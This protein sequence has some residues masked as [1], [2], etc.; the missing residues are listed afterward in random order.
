[1]SLPLS[2]PECLDI[3]VV[4]IQTRVSPLANQGGNS[5]LRPIQNSRLCLRVAA[6]SRYHG[7]SQLHSHKRHFEPPHVV[8]SFRAVWP[9]CHH[10]PRYSLAVPW[11]RWNLYCNVTGMTRWDGKRLIL[12]WQTSNSLASVGCR[13]HGCLRISCFGTL[14]RPVLPRSNR[15]NIEIGLDQGL[16]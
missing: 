6:F 12:A 8:T 15:G 1:M 11:S 10:R 2:L 16:F 14:D 9:H 3:T 7:C 13:K 4:V 5:A